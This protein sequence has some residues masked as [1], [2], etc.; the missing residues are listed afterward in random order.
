M[1]LARVIGTVVAAVQHPAYEAQTLL[2]CESIEPGGKPTNAPAFIA[3]DR[4]NAGVGDTV[5]VNDEGNGARQVFG[6]APKDKLPIR[7]VVV[8]VVD[9]AEESASS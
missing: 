5:L 7:T 8:G 4:A 6:M 1:K 2:L 3:V 9:L